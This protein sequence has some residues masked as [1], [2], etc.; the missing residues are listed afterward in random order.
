MRSDPLFT[1]G[2]ADVLD[3]ATAE[4]ALGMK[5]DIATRRKSAGEG[6]K[7]PWPPLIKMREDVH[8]KTDGLLNGEQVPNVLLAGDESSQ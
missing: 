3:H 1:K 7:H 6:G 4:I 2:P 5:L 8:R